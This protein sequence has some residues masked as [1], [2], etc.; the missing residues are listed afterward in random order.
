MK[1]IIIC[2]FLLIMFGATSV[3][4]Q[5]DM[6]EM[7]SIVLDS[8]Q[9]N[10]FP[11]DGKWE[12]YWG[13]LLEPS[14]ISESRHIP[15]YIAVPSSWNDGKVYRESIESTGYGT[16]RLKLHIPDEDVNKQ[17]AISFHYIGS[18]YRIWVDG[19]EYDGAGVV[20]T[21]AIE[22]TPLLKRNI[23]FFEP[24]DTIVEIVIQVSNFSFREGGIIHEVT[25]G[26]PD[27][28]AGLLINEN[29]LNFF[30]IG[31][32]FII[33]LYHLLVYAKRNNEP[34]ILFI[35]FSSLALAIRTFTVSESVILP[36]IDMIGWENLVRIEYL[37]EEIFFICLVLTVKFLFPR[38]VHQSMVYISIITASLLSLIILFTPS[39]IFTSM[40]PYHILLLVALS[41]YFVFYVGILAIIR[42]R[43]G[44]IL[45]IIGALFIVFG[46]LNDLLKSMMLIHTF[47]MIQY[48]FIIFIMLQAVIISNKYTVL[49]KENESL[50]SEL[51]ELTE[52]LEYKIQER[53][54]KL[55]QK[56]NELIELQQSRTKLL[57]NIAH[58]MGTPLVGVQTY[59][60]IMKEGKV[61]LDNQ[62][63][64]PKLVDEISYIRRLNN[65]LFDLSKLESQNLKFQMEIVQ[66][67]E[68]ITKIYRAVQK[69]VMLPSQQ[70]VF[71]IAK[72]ETKINGE[73]ACVELDNIRIRQVMENYIGNALKFSKNISK[74]TEITLNCYVNRNVESEYEVIIEV[75]DN[76]TGIAEEEVDHVFERFYKKREGNL[77]GSGLGLAIV[78]EI[79]EQHGGKV[80]VESKM[81]EGSCFYFSLPITQ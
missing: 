27:T 19:E 32:L 12:F 38:E 56:N 62:I 55:H 68:Y 37:S 40:L 9:Q 54:E 2:I 22:E 48:V 57:A 45:H 21:N 15:D 25:Y 6:E 69:E 65:D 41:C 42:K 49:F 77:D 36:I 16:Y 61:D 34:A 50:T 28:L 35:G 64:I 10:P 52:T 71:K 14:D 43:E 63:V 47:S 53:T 59:L 11:L 30:T 1:K 18:A 20:G 72:L 73:E 29:L 3:F 66:I 44:A 81:G 74:E 80:G 4:S 67:K 79:V 31:G 70:A 39:Q 78:K 23:I 26:D 75:I 76:G 5:I 46:V 58:D 17:K 13:E 51:F 7:G 33:G 24:L 8:E 60:Q